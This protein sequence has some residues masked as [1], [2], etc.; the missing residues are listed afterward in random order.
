[1]KLPI[2]LKL[3][4]NYLRPNKSTVSIINIIS[5]LG[6]LLGRCVN[7]SFVNNEWLWSNMERKNIKC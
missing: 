6:V 3:A 1:M 5:T 7:Y 4:L 2:S